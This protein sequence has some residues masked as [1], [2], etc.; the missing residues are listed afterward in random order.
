MTAESLLNYSAVK[1]GSMIRDRVISPVE[2]VQAALDRI[3]QVNPQINAFRRLMGE[4]ALALAEQADRDIK[5]GQ[6]RG[7]LHGVPYAAKDLINV[8]GVPATGGSKIYVDYVPTED[9]AVVTRMNRAGAILLGKLN[10]HELAWG[11]TSRNPHFGPTL[12]PWNL[13]TSCGGSSSG[14][15]AALAAGML[16]LALGSDTGGSIRIPACLCGVVGLKPTYG[17]VSRK[18][19]LPLSW[20]LDHLGPMAVAVEDLALALNSLAGHDPL[21]PT[22]SARPVP[23]YLE[24]LKADLAGFT[25]G[26]PRNFFPDDPKPEIKALVQTAIKDMAALGAEIREVELPEVTRGDQASFAILFSEASANMESIARSR[27]H[28][29]SEEILFNLRLGLAIPATRYVQAQRVRTKIIQDMAALFTKV[30]VVVTPGTMVEAPPIDS[31]VVEV[32][33]RRTVDVR[34]AMTRYSRYFN[35]T[36]N[37]VLA[38]PCGMS[39][40]GLPVGMQLIGPAF[41]EKKVL[42]AG[43]AYQQA[44]PLT[45]A[46]PV[47]A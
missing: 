3:N 17:L 5:A 20:S 4:Q 45:P 14:S 6:W 16:P 11:I 8:A 30:D 12:N 41:G 43:Y 33:P 29:L 38:M 47:L 27:P 42:Q 35:L 36:G 10:M 44:H 7:F 31:Y 1:L 28:D 26:V 25:I 37:P 19:V 15:A 24:G 23:D 18:G 9:A 21:D 40:S 46:R 22:T 34:T 13:N 2:L 32:E 39:K